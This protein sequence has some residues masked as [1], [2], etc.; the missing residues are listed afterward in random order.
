M[1]PVFRR[2]LETYRYARSFVG[3]Y[4]G[5]DGFNLEDAPVAVNPGDVFLGLDWDAGIAVDDQAIN[6]AT[7][8]PPARNENR[9]HNLRFAA[10]AAP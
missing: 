4:V 1:E 6:L 3:R 8:S 2:H 10:V 9:F 7:A 5:L